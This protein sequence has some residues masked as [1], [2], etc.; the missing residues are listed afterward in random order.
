MKAQ[1]NGFTLIELVIAIF[2]LVVAVIGVYNSFSTV[3]TLT[4]GASSRLTAFYLAQEGIEIVRNMRDN[5]WHQGAENGWDYGLDCE[6]GCE[7][8]YRTGTSMDPGSGLTAF[9]GNGNYL[10]INNN[11]G[12][13]SY[14]IIGDYS[15]TKFK[16]KITIVSQNENVL[17]V[18]VLVT[19][20]VKDET[21][22]AEVEEYLYN[23]Y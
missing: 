19:W 15:S 16:R 14:D 6:Y 9:S 8:D 20:E 13:Y 2:I 7:A 4:A 5:N 21:F 22:S 17:K 18:Y 11:N 3:V 10:N 23:W 12:F 1:N